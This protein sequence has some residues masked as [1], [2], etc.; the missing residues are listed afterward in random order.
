VKEAASKD[1]SAQM[2][3]VARG[4]SQAEEATSRKLDVA[5]VEVVSVSFGEPSDMA[6]VT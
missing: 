6:E 2:G 5:E 1:P 4:G 3:A